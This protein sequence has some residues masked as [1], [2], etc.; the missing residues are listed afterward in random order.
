MATIVYA[1]NSTSG[2]R[3]S[4]SKISAAELTKMWALDVRHGSVDFGTIIA[5][6]FCCRAIILGAA[7]VSRSS[8]ISLQCAASDSAPIMEGARLLYFCCVSHGH[9]L[10]VS[11]SQIAHLPL[12]CASQLFS[13]NWACFLLKLSQRLINNVLRLL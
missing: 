9:N 2:M 6:A 1:T 4:N 12:C 7:W 5:L 10:V 3:H 11:L 8:R 13:R